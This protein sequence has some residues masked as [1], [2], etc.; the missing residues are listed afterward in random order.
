VVPSGNYFAMGDNRDNSY[1]S[2]YW[3]FVPQE[4]IIG[5]PLIIYWSFENSP[6]DYLKTSAS[7]RL[8]HASRVLFDFFDLDSVESDVC[9]SAVNC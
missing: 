2:R 7:E 6:D 9:H 3:G 4:N 1:D 8:L 5:R